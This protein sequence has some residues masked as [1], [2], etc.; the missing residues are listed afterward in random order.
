MAS[1]RLLRL[2]LIALVLLAGCEDPDVGRAAGRL[3]C[4]V[5]GYVGP[6]DTPSGIL[7]STDGGK[8]W[9]PSV[10]KNGVGA[11]RFLFARRAGSSV[12]E[13]TIRYGTENAGVGDSIPL[14]GFGSKCSE[15]FQQ[16]QTWRRN[17]TTERS[18]SP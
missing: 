7:E 12:E 6:S 9:E 15:R 14:K 16:S 18:Q 11:R 5:G 8:I 17:P 13:A 4:A 2:A 10:L 1:P 3:F